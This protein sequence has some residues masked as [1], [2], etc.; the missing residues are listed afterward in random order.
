M[1]WHARCM[2]VQLASARLITRMVATQLATNTVIVFLLLNGCL[3]HMRPRAIRLTGGGRTIGPYAD[4][5]PLSSQFQGWGWV[6]GSGGG[7][8]GGA[9]AG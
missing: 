7:G 6:G 1:H 9:G 8:G 5:L 3:R 4:S 2:H